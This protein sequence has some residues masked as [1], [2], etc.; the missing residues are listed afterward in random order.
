MDSMF[1]LTVYT[2]EINKIE[3]MLHIR[4]AERHCSIADVCMRVGVF[5]THH[6]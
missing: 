2:T 6:S 1:S 3:Q 4:M 5:K